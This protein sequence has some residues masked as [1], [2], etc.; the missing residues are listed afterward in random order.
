MCLL[1]DYFISV[2]LR[3]MMPKKLLEVASINLLPAPVTTLMFGCLGTKIYDPEVRNEG[4]GQLSD[5]D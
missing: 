1:I 4:S 5:I 3:Q 2:A